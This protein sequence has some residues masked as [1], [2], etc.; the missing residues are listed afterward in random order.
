MSKRQAPPVPQTDEGGTQI[1]S[2]LP[3]SE[4][5][6]YATEDGLARFYLRAEG[7]TVWLTQKQIAELFQVSL[8]TVNEHLAGI[9]A[10]GELEPER[11]LRKFRIVQQEGAREVRRQVDHYNLDAIMAVGYRVT[12]PRGTQFRQWATTQL[13]D[14][15][16]KGFVLD[17]VRLKEPGGWDYFDELLEKIREIRA[18]EKRFYQKVRDAF[19]LSIDYKDDPEA[20]GVFFATVQNKMLYAVTGKTAAEIVVERADPNQPNMNLTTWKGSRVRKTD[21][22]VA[23]N[24]LSASEIRELNRIST[25]FL[26]YAEDRAAQRKNLRMDDWKQYVDRFVDFNERPLLKTAGSISHEQMQ[27]TAHIRYEQFDAK[28]Q[29]AERVAADAQDIRELE[30]MEKRGRKGKEDKNAS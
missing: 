26:D 1:G 11:T 24:Y 2:S 9:F 21:V 14:Y 17:D 18:S 10:E 7:G 29:L 16:V 3:Q 5:V 23:K 30:D 22:I 25:M 4:L 15:L 28:R 20:T 8:P 27:K 13:R 12:S 6:L 19:A